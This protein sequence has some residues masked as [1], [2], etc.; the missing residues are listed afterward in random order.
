MRGA[1]VRP[2]RCAPAPRVTASAARGSTC[3]WGPVAVILPALAVVGAA[4][5][6]LVAVGLG[7][8]MGWFRLSP[9]AL[10]YTLVVLSTVAALRSM[11]AN[12]S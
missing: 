11:P 12:Q 5:T 3:R 4:L 10:P 2:R 6:A 1:V 7:V 9:G 8:A